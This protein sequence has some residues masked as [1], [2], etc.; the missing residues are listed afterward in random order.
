ME[1]IITKFSKLKSSKIFKKCIKNKITLKINKDIFYKGKIF[2]FFLKIKILIQN[3]K[4]MFYF[5]ISF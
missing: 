1:T 4:Y 3:S 2:M 5:F